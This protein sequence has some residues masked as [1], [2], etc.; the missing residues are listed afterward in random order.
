LLPLTGALAVVAIAVGFAVAGN[1]PAPD[2]PT[3]SLASFYA[4]HGSGQLAS[5]ALLS[6]GGL[7]FLV[8]TAT[9][10]NVLRLAGGESMAILCLA[11]GVVMVVG[12]TILAGF[13]LALGDVAQ[14]LDARR[15]CRLCTC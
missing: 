3:G 10:V 2:A 6:L 7:L 4:S 15:L 8:F 12:L 13:A 11:G 5:G 9:V 14:H 1:T